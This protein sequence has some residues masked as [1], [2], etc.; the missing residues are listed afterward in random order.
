MVK[1]EKSSAYHSEL[2]KKRK[3]LDKIDENPEKQPPILTVDIPETEAT[4]QDNQK[5]QSSVLPVKKTNIR[6]ESL[7]TAATSVNHEENRV[8]NEYVLVD[9]SLLTSLLSVVKCTEC[10]TSSLSFCIS[11]E[12]KG[13]ARNIQCTERHVRIQD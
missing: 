6:K 9:I 8:S 12:V 4:S 10:D 7:K 13:F 1:R 3:S 11:D 5:T 2:W